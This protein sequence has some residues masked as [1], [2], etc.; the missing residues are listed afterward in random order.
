MPRLFQ[1]SDGRGRKGRSVILEDAAAGRRAHA[2]RGEHILDRQRQ[3][4]QGR[5]IAAVPAVVGKFGL[6]K[7]TFGRHRQESLHAGIDGGNAVEQRLR[8]LDRREFAGAQTG[9]RF[10]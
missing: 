6:G 9:A 3:P 2:G 1:A 5:V 8:Q 4:Q 10:G 7:G